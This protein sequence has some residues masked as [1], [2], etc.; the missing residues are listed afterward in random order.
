MD[1][2]RLMG[3]L[4][5]LLEIHIVRKYGFRKTVTE[6]IRDKLLAGFETERLKLKLI[7]SLRES[8]NSRQDHARKLKKSQHTSTIKN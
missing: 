8:E 7:K 4:Y 1:Y 2:S 6:E 3:P 5:P